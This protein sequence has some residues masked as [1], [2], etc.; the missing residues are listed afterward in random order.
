MYL[1][2]EGIDT[3]GKST[4]IELLRSKFT[5][6]IFTH[7]PGGSELGKRLRG[8]LLEEDISLSKETELLLFLADRSEHIHRVI[9]PNKDR[10]IIS[11]RSLISGI[12]Y[13]KGFAFEDLLKFNRFATQDV[14]PSC[15]VLLELDALEL[16]KRLGAKKRDKIEQRGVEFLLEIQGCMLKACQALGIECLRIDA[17]LS[18]QEIHQKIVERIET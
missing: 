3:A 11:D 18:I 8:I 17:R 16:Q 4:Q 10:L 14:L 12:A 1:A 13:G 5:N 6:A 2:L 9:L 7:E 15:V